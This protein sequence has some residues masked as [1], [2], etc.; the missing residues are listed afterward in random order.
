VEQA[1][2]FGSNVDE[3]LRAVP[4]HFGCREMSEGFCAAEGLYHPVE[5]RGQLGIR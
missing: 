4:G 1:F 5:D 3:G 2:A